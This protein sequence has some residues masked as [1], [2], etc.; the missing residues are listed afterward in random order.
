MSKKV[1]EGIFPPLATPFRDRNLDLEG[2]KYNLGYLCAGGIHGCLV[3]GSNGEFPYL[4]D[5]EK[6]KVVETVVA[7]LDS[8]RTILVGTGRE[9]T[10]ATIDFT[11]Q[12]AE[13]GAD[14]AVILPP[15]YFV[16][17]MTQDILIDFYSSVA[18]QVPIP[19]LIYNMPGFTGINLSA[20]T[21]VKLSRH[22]NIIGVKD[23]SGDISQIASTIKDAREGFSV[24]A[25]SGSYV[26]PTMLLGGR[27]GLP[28]VANVIPG[29][30][31]KLYELCKE[32][33][34]D[35]ARELQ[36]Q[37]L[38]L[39][40]AVTKRYGVPGLKKAMDLIKL[41]GGLPREPLKPVGEE[42]EREIQS[43]LEEFFEV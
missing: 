30:L 9:S 35:A 43:L 19:V 14:V 2:L 31:V 26:F 24:M 12:V 16:S 41:H 22:A 13:K 34:Y 21:L 27:G 42:G 40:Q 33:Q 39:N 8:S 18:D 6:L 4:T 5:L 36:L 3:L 17:A 20:A 23:S 15:H 1:L 28:A 7:E 32:G 10:Q 38:P 25:G 37:I 11:H 29:K